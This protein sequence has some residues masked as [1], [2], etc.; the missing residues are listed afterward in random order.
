MGIKELV[1]TY[2]VKIPYSNV[3][4][5]GH[6]SVERQSIAV[7]VMSE[8]IWQRKEISLLRFRLLQV[9]T[10]LNLCR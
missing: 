6:R 9:I 8:L 4:S 10:I 3:S 2:V 5:D 1:D 7:V